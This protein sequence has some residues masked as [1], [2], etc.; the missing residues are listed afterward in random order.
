ME[1]FY[2]KKPKE[3]MQFN[4]KTF[5]HIEKIT[6]KLWRNSKKV[7]FY[8]FHWHFKMYGMKFN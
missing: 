6:D 3:L 5:I 4:F 7:F 2:R 8:W 1:L